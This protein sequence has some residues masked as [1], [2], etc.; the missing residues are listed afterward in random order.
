MTVTAQSQ[1]REGTAVSCRVSWISEA[2]AK[3][4]QTVSKTEAQ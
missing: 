1:A 3:K 2:E 4:A